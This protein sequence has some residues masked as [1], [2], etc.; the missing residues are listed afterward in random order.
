MELVS[1][2]IPG[3]SGV[4]YGTGARTSGMEPTRVKRFRKPRVPRSVASSNPQRMA[5]ISDMSMR[6]SKCKQKR[7]IAYRRKVGSFVARSREGM[8]RKM[9]R[10]ADPGTMTGSIYNAACWA[11]GVSSRLWATVYVTI[12]ASWRDGA[13]K[14]RD[15]C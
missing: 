14:S 13:V 4:E 6:V 7:F 3:Y 10:P 8:E 5:Q 1:L 9:K 12:V 15:C 2:N 11:G